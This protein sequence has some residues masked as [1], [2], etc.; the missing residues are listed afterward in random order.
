VVQTC[1]RTGDADAKLNLGLMYGEEAGVI[2]DNVY[3]HMWGNIAAS[4][5]EKNGLKLRDLVAGK[6]TSSQLKTA[7]KFAR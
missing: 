6:M 5:G 1:F 2:Q 4:N 7:E 3:S